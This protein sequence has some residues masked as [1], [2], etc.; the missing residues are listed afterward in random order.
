MSIPGSPSILEHFGNIEDPRMTRRRLHKLVDI[1]GI[2]IC[3][4]ICGAENWQEIEQWGKAKRVWLKTFLELPNGIPSHDT[5]GRVFGLIDDQAFQKAFLDWVQDVNTI[6]NGQVIAIDGKCSR[7][8]HDRANGK[9]AIYMVSA[10]ATENSLVLGQ[11]KTDEKSNE[12]TAIPKLLR[13]LAIKGCIVTIDAAGC[14]K[15]IAKQIREQGADYVLALKGNQGSLH[16][17]AK[18]YFEIALKDGFKDIEHDFFEETNGGHGRVEVRRYWTLTQKCWLEKIEGW[19]DLKVLGMVE[20]ERHVGE[21]VSVERRHYIASLPGDAKQFAKAVR[22]H[23]GIENGLH[24]CLDVAMGEDAARTRSGNSAANFA[25][26]RH[27]ALNLLKA[28]K[29]K[30]VGIKAKGKV[31]GWDHDYLLKVLEK[32][33]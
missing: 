1:M 12:I 2:A 33:K 18:E 13:S 28:E 32:A 6:F 5:F 20:S 31:C 24:W 3:A 29:T 15:K 25:V 11:V 27:T 7:G 14:Q 17:E 8:S 23:W 9:S 19:Q 4:V 26:L 16:E 30:K 10:W 21:K 22:G